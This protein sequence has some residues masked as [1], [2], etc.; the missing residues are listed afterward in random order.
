MSI[1]KSFGLVLKKY[2]NLAGIS[3]EEL[4]ASCELDRT[5]ISLLERGKRNATLVTIFKISNSL[6]IKPSELIKEIEDIIFC[7][8]SEEDIN[9]L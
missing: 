4:A 3:Q 1:E 8:S 2:R 7:E 5:F 9:I 6:K